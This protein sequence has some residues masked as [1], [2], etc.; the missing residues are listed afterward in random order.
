ML[1]IIFFLN[2]MNLLGLAPNSKIQL[3]NPNEIAFEE[4]TP[5]SLEQEFEINH[6]P[7]TL[8]QIHKR[9][10]HNLHIIH[11]IVRSPL[12]ELHLKNTG[13]ED[14]VRIHEKTLTIISQ[15]LSKGYS[16][17]ES[18]FFALYHCYLKYNINNPRSIWEKKLPQTVFDENTKEKLLQLTLPF[19]TLLINECAHYFHMDIEERKAFEHQI[20]TSHPLQDSIFFH[21]QVNQHLCLVEKEQAIENDEIKVFLKHYERKHIYTIALNPLFDIKNLF[22]IVDD[23]I[24]KEP[25]ETTLIYF[26]NIHYLSSIYAKTGHHL[27][28]FQEFLY[29]RE[30]THPHTKK[31]VKLPSHIFTCSS[32]NKKFLCETYDPSLI[33]RLNFCPFPQFENNDFNTK[34]KIEQEFESITSMKL[35]YELNIETHH[36]DIFPVSQPQNTIV[37]IPINKSFSIKNNILT[38]QDIDRFLKRKHN[39][40]LS[41]N[42]L[43]LFCLFQFSINNH[44]KCL[45]VEGETGIGKT[46]SFN[47]FSLLTKN[48]KTKII[49]LSNNT[50]I[51]DLLK[52]PQTNLP[53]GQLIS[54]ILNNDYIS[55]SEANTTDPS[56]FYWLSEF[57][58]HPQKEEF[59]LNLFYHLE[60]WKELVFSNDCLI[61]IDINPEENYKKRHPLPQFFKK[62]T[63]YI[64]FKF[65]LDTNDLFNIVKS[66][67][68]NKKIP[69]E[70]EKL[71]DFAEKY[72]TFYKLWGKLGTQLLEKEITL[73]CQTFI[74]YNDE[75]PRVNLK[76]S[77]FINFIEVFF[78]IFS[79]QDDQTPSQSLFKMLFSDYH[80]SVLK[81]DINSKQKKDDINDQTQQVLGHIIPT[82][83]KNKLKNHSLYPP[84]IENDE[85]LNQLKKSLIKEAQNN[86]EWEKSSICLF[87][88]GHLYLKIK[89]NNELYQLITNP[90]LN[91]PYHPSL[92]HFKS[93]FDTW[94]KDNQENSPIKP[95]IELTFKSLNQSK[96]ALKLMILPFIT[97]LKE[98]SVDE[99]KG[100][101]DI[102]FED[103]VFNIKSS[104]V[105]FTKFQNLT[106]FLKRFCL[107]DQQQL[108]HNSQLIF[109]PHFSSLNHL[110]TSI[111]K[112][113]CQN[114]Q[115]KS[116]PDQLIILDHFDKISKESSTETNNFW[117]NNML[118]LN[119]FESIPVPPNVH[120]LFVHRNNSII[121][122]RSEK[123]RILSST[124]HLP[125]DIEQLFSSKSLLFKIFKQDFL[126]N[127]KNLSVIGRY[128]LEESSLIPLSYP[129]TI[130]VLPQN[131]SLLILLQFFYEYMFLASEEHLFDSNNLTTKKVLSI[132]EKL[133]PLITSS[134]SSQRDLKSLLSKS[135]NTIKKLPP[136]TLHEKQEEI[137]KKIEKIKE[138]LLQKFQD[139]QSENQTLIMENFIEDE[140][141][142]TSNE[143]LE[144]SKNT[145]DFFKEIQSQCQKLINTLPQT[146]DKWNHWKNQIDSLEKLI[147]LLQSSTNNTSLLDQKIQ[148]NFDSLLKIITQIDSSIQERKQEKLMIEKDFHSF[149]NHLIIP[150]TPPYAT[151]L[152]LLSFQPA[153]QFKI[154]KAETNLVLCLISYQTSF[155]SFHPQSS[156]GFYCM[157]NIGHCSYWRIVQKDS[158]I[159]IEEEFT[160]TEYQLFEKWIQ[161]RNRPTFR[162]CQTLSPLKESSQQKQLYLCN[163]ENQPKLAKETAIKDSCFLLSSDLAFKLGFNIYYEQ[164]S[165]DFA[166][167]VLKP[168]FKKDLNPDSHENFISYDKEERPQ[169]DE[170]NN[171]VFSKTPIDD[172]LIIKNTFLSLGML[173]VS[174]QQESRLT[175]THELLQHFSINPQHTIYLSENENF[176]S[177]LGLS[178]KEISQ[179]KKNEISI[180]QT[181]SPLIKALKEGGW[182]ILTTPPFNSKTLEIIQFFTSFLEGCQSIDITIEN[183]AHRVHIHPSFKII[184]L[185]APHELICFKEQTA[186]LFCTMYLSDTPKEKKEKKHLIY[187]SVYPEN[188]IAVARQQLEE[189]EGL[190]QVIGEN[191]IAEEL[192]DYGLNQNE[193]DPI[194]PDPPKELTLTS[195]LKN[196]IINASP[197]DSIDSL[198]QEGELFQLLH[199][200]DHPPT[201][202]MIFN[203]YL[204][205][206]LIQLQ[207]SHIIQKGEDENK[208]QFTFLYTYS[209]SQTLSEIT[210]PFQG[211]FKLGKITNQTSEKIAKVFDISKESISQEEQ[212]FYQEKGLFISKD[213]YK[214]ITTITLC[215]KEKTNQSIFF[216][217]LSGL[218]KTT[219]GSLY[220]E[221]HQIPLY[222]TT[223]SPSSNLTDLMELKP[224]N[225]QLSSLPLKEQMKHQ[226]SLLIL[227]EANTN[228]N[229]LY[230]IYSL[231]GGL[232]TDSF[233]PLCIITGNLDT[234]IGRFRLPQPLN[235]MFIQ[236]PFD[237][238]GETQ[239]EQLIKTLLHHHPQISTRISTLKFK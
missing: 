74:N 203:P 18:L 234:W 37:S 177:L 158:E 57:Q 206:P 110:S 215:L 11:N 28:E 208:H 14:S 134:P 36:L 118:F 76:D 187:H 99:M 227:D 79:Y 159:I 48:R 72:Q 219:L 16:I 21:Q 63:P 217:G 152:R 153:C 154:L 102:H 136:Y 186:S 26:Q 42:A 13:F 4:T 140:E 9:L 96:Y 54:S 138:T 8:T 35:A 113:I 83:N 65:Q 109:C 52:D 151:P 198:S 221:Y 122:A 200:K 5:L 176:E 163:K 185:C 73:L 1:I 166:I 84:S 15:L 180:D 146:L 225:I 55:L 165:H 32:I 181:Q 199:S 34:Q 2:I 78:N 62:I 108:S 103:D 120:F 133:L 116:L 100:V 157:N 236:V 189:P 58:E 43:K 23:I 125:S 131:S 87:F 204:W 173:F 197:I 223:I 167:F 51:L 233:P 7:H 190:S 230:K 144:S 226:K 171:K 31:K 193:K 95:L 237:R 155:S 40:L 20:N 94:I 148:E 46:S 170:L 25:Q 67:K 22:L 147:K 188:L 38:T 196:I 75:H 164:C 183:T 41:Q 24:K 238:F 19:S 178:P 91:I 90:S 68:T 179:L 71:L 145:Y 150:S 182:L 229:L 12:E 175:T 97:M 81:K 205:S 50:D 106:N 214:A 195:S 3:L 231:L 207:L 201:L 88:M 224:H 143:S 101:K 202:F 194:S 161:E 59:T 149:F 212:E 53:T 10:I 211:L 191:N 49:S 80:L 162:N 228:I 64:Q 135:L 27:T 111:L 128:W 92:R 132:Q 218:G 82:V 70:D 160:Q 141:N 220:A 184:A 86:N 56:L 129:H 209:G 137:L 235:D 139:I 216:Q 30:F 44:T 127:F 210:Q 142:Y 45:I 114:K 77:E 29:K 130:K 222:Q 105:I 126:Y 98:E 117:D 6:L 115:I 232:S 192:T 47:I 89:I 239:E 33:S 168:Q 107:N 121:S 69:I 85:D 156:F 39:F 213:L 124:I 172:N 123:D 104:Y 169:Q 119:E 112:K 17:Q 174:T 66:I 93:T 60:D 61:L